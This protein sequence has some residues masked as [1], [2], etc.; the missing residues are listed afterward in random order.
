MSPDEAQK[1]LDAIFEDGIRYALKTGRGRSIAALSVC[2]RPVW[3][4]LSGRAKS[5]IGIRQLPG[6]G[7]LLV[8]QA[9]LT[10]VSPGSVL[11]RRE[12]VLSE[13]DRKAASLRDDDPSP[14]R[15]SA[16][17]LPFSRESISHSLKIYY[18][19]MGNDYR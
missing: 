6:Q 5:R 9:H 11:S 10:G 16:G 3:D 15:V 8:I 14:S 19:I 7:M 4:E 12:D 2:L 18:I 13:I 17:L 1:A